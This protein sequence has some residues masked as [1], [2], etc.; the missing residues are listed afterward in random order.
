MTQV[1]K[2]DSNNPSE[3]SGATSKKVKFAKVP[4][5]SRWKYWEVSWRSWLYVGLYSSLL[6]L[7][8]NLSLLL[9]GVFSHG[10]I[11]DGVG[12]VAKGTAREIDGL[13]TGYHI[14]IN[15]LSTILLISSNYAMQILCAPTR[16][17]LDRAHSQGRWLDI[18]LV[19]LRNLRTVERRRVM[20]FWILAFS[21]VPLHLL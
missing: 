6:V 19:S 12:T 13:S 21:S 4:F 20:L 17:E 8:I 3:R 14:L 10:G 1:R 11:R 7:I 9:V 16:S 5:W 2:P 15:V 18:G